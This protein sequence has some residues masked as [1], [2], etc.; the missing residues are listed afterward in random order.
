M[1]VDGIRRILL[2]E[3]DPLG[4]GDNPNLADEYDSYIPEIA[5]LVSSG[6][7]SDRVA[8]YLRQIESDLGVAHDDDSSLR[9]AQRLLHAR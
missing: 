5:Q 9:T 4:V 8:Q 2:E 7:S 6:S 3:W 1:N